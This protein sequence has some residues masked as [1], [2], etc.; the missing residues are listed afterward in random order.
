MKTIISLLGP[1]PGSIYHIWKELTTTNNEVEVVC[2]NFSNNEKAFERLKKQSNRLA[3]ER[4]CEVLKANER[5]FTY[6]VVNVDSWTKEPLHPMESVYYAIDKFKANEADKLVYNFLKDEENEY[7]I[8]CM[9]GMKNRIKEMSPSKGSVSFFGY[10]NNISKLD[11]YKEVPNYLKPYIVNCLNISDEG[12]PCG[13]CIK[14]KHNTYDMAD[15]ARGLS[16]EEFL[17]KKLNVLGR[18]PNPFP[19]TIL[20]ASNGN[21]DVIDHPIYGSF[22]GDTTPIN[23][24]ITE[25]PDKWIFA[26]NN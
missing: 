21:F 24:P 1:S 15:L 13:V 8:Q 3:L 20:F 2:M 10:E 11:V 16:S 18:G 19:G 17:T 5:D 6:T 22:N 26:A 12:V 9:N 14:C 23:Y 7:M 25:V 4:A